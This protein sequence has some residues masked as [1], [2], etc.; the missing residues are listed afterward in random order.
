MKLH[1]YKWLIVVLSIFPFFGNSQTTLLS[2]T[3]SGGSLPSGWSNVDNAGTGDKWKF[4][5]PGNRNITAGN[6]SGN[7]AIVDSDYFGSSSNQDAVLTTSS[8]DASSYETITLSYDYQYRDYSLPETC[9]VEVYNGS[10]WTAVASYTTGGDNYPNSNNVSINITS[11]TNLSSSSKIRFTYSGNYDYWW[12]IDNIVITGTL[13]P[14]VNGP[15]GI[16]GND[17]SSA[18][19]G[20]YTPSSLRNSSNNLPTDNQ[21]VKYW[22]D[23]SGNNKTITNSGSA[24]FQSGGADLINGNAKLTASALNRQFKTNSNIS[25]R[26]LIV[27]S[28]PGSK[29]SFEAVVGFQGDK[30]I[31]RSSSGNNKWQY[32]GGGDGVNNDTWSTNTGESYING[33]TSNTGTFNNTLHFVSQTRPSNYSNKFYIGGYYSNRPF[34]GDISEVLIFNTELSLVEKI[35]ID[36]YLSAKYDISLV[37]NDYY[38]QDDSGNGDYDYHVAGI[39]RASDGSSHDNS[40]GTGI[41]KINSPSSLNTDDYLFWGENSLSATYE[42]STSNDYSERLNS[43]WRV[44]KRNNVGTVTVSVN[45]SDIDLSGKQ[46]CADLHLVVSSSSNFSTKVSYALTLNGGVYSATN[47]SFA[48]GDYFTLEY[49][50]LIVIENTGFIGGSGASGAPNTTDAC[51]KLLIKSSADGSYDINS[52]AH[53]REVEIETGAQIS[54]TDD[55][56]LI[57][58]NDIIN[59]GTMTIAENASLC[60]QNTGVNNNSGSGTYSITRSGNT[61]SYVYNIW[62]SP[63]TT[64]NLTTVFSD[65]NPCDIWTFDKDLQAWKFDFANGFS[66]TCNGNS[67]TFGTNDIITGGDGLMDVTRGYFI[68][69]DLTAARVYNGTVNNGDYST[70]ISTT[71]LGNPGGTDWDDDDWNLLGNPYPSAL[72]ADS[73]W[74]ENAIINN[75]ITDALYFWDEADTTGGYNQNSDYASWNLTG[76]VQSGNSN[77]KP[78]GN[79]ASGQGFWVVANQNTNVIFNNNMR[80]T[81]NSQFF[82]QNT[83]NDKHNAWFSFIS[84]SNYKNHILVGYSSITT[85]GLDAGYDAHKLVGNSHVRFASIMGQEEYVIQSLAPIAVNDSKV[86]PLVVFTDES[87][88]HTFINY[89]R[90]NIPNDFKIFLRDKDLGIDTELGSSDYQVTLTANT[91]YADRFQLVFKNELGQAGGAGTSKGGAKG[92]G[93]SGNI[94]SVE[95]N[96]FDSSF[97]VIQSNDFITLINDEGFSGAIQLRD[98]TGK[99]IWQK[100]SIKNSNSERVNISQLTG[101]TYFITIMK[102]GER[103]FFKQFIRP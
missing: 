18:L 56:Y 3:F 1:Y 64:G 55:K 40:Q 32:A 74:K 27:V 26:T 45:A 12:A 20:W 94:T 39:G 78:L 100:E 41:I 46:D 14:T 21:S 16:G 87:G 92:S 71:T 79:I 83:A 23:L 82:K 68:P 77:D 84:P 17:G 24:T 89:E 96:N 57:V 36:N 51:Y 25:G 44:S 22:L 90:E 2:E 67:V 34:T 102:N 80:A 50:D 69:G 52:N 35:I 58:D 7:Y 98:I 48:N 38:T 88:T 19:A 70:A 4:N 33:S 95:T 43:T 61:S 47:V 101:G 37:A 30:G 97:K 62:S 28:N 60:Q 93:N 11:A 73:F 91:E 31:R 13:P 49:Q 66:T 6:F 85:D 103:L 29:N 65:A 53:V 9:L 15:G 63:I 99:L 72:S 76:G 81:E 59:N 54:I 8:F 10:T 5:D 86:I 42:F 75:R